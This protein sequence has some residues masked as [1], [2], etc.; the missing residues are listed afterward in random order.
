MI[1]ILPAPGTLEIEGPTQGLQRGDNPTPTGL[2][3]Q[4][5]LF[6]TKL[7]EEKVKNYFQ[8]QETL[9]GNLH[10]F[11]MVVLGQCNSVLRSHIIGFADYEPCRSNG[12]CIWLFDN[13]KI[14]TSKFDTTHSTSADTMSQ[15][16]QTPFMLTFRLSLD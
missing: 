4:V 15:S 8:K 11:F 7:F 14:V 13:I 6:D 10:A 2:E 3:G 12:D 5:T 9:N 16:R 1:P